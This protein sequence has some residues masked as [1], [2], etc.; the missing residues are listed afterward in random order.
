[1]TYKMGMLKITNRCSIENNI[2]ITKRINVVISIKNTIYLIMI[3]E[4]WLMYEERLCMT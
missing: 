4:S 1:M 2:M 3:N